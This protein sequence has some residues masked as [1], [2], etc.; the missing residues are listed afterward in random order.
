[1]TKKNGEEDEFGLGAPEKEGGLVMV[2]GMVEAVEA[3][4]VD[5]GARRLLEREETRESISGVA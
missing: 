5:A 4:E 1:M 3:G 2:A